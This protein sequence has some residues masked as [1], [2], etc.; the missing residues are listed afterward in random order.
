MP[1]AVNK[2][3]RPEFKKWVSKRSLFSLE[4]FRL[5]S[6]H[7]SFEIKTQKPPEVALW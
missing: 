3:T 6:I 1:E 4:D 2:Q 7:L 5:C